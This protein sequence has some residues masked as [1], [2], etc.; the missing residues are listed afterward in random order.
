MTENTESGNQKNM[1]RENTENEGVTLSYTVPGKEESVKKSKDVVRAMDYIGKR[2]GALTISKVQ[3]SKYKTYF[4]L[5]KPPAFTEE[6]KQIVI[7]MESVTLD[8]EPYRLIVIKEDEDVFKTY[9]NATTE[10][11]FDKMFT[12]FISIY[13]THFLHEVTFGAK[14]IYKSR[15][16]SS[17]GIENLDENGKECFDQIQVNKMSERLGKSVKKSNCGNRTIQREIQRALRFEEQE[18]YSYG[19]Y[20][21]DETDIGFWTK[22]DFQTPDIIDFKVFPIITLFDGLTM[23]LERISDRAGYRINVNLILSWLLPRYAILLNRCKSLPN[24]R[25][26]DNGASCVECA[27]N[28]R[29]SDDGLSCK[30]LSP[31]GALGEVI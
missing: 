11:T 7:E 18:F 30:F 12:D 17:S 31:T 10:S 14:L 21:T 8:L 3:C 16:T 5:R 22:N 2:S 6:F 1:G 13:G 24:H 20:I 27:K 28:Q 4:N 9:L 23:S 25:L 15:I 19:G 29:P 26:S